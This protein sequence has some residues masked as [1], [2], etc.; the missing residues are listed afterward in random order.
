MPKTDELTTA[1]LDRANYLPIRYVETAL[2]EPELMP[3]GCRSSI[4][5]T[6]EKIKAAREHLAKL[7][8]R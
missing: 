3:D 7:I 8:K 4:P 6:P 5:P 2:G 1:I